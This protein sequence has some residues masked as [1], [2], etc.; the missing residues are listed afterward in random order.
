MVFV[1][2]WYDVLSKEIAALIVAIA[3][4][5]AQ[6]IRLRFEQRRSRLASSNLPEI[7]QELALIRGQLVNSDGVAI[8]DEISKGLR[9]VREE[10]GSIRDMVE[11]SALRWRVE[12]KKAHIG[13][14][15]CDSEGNFTFLNPALCEL[16][17]RAE[18][19]LMGRGWLASVGSDSEDRL[20]FWQSLLSSAKQKL[21][22]EEVVT[23]G[24]TSRR[25]RIKAVP[26]VSRVTGHLVT[27]YGSVDEIT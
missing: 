4:L 8:R 14:F 3:V 9:E 19:E 1:A 7:R 24:G 23:V 6:E 26:H 17:G 11:L 2:T 20:A 16:F 18:S 25:C 22:F 10:L 15:E 27:Y 5:L 12:V 13:V 21:P